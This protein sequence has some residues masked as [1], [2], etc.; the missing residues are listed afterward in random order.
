MTSF[1][2]VNALFDLTW[3]RHYKW[4][5]E[6]ERDYKFKFFIV[7][8]QN[9]HIENTIVYCYRKMSILLDY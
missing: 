3:N 2:T 9:I 1:C 7:V 4:T 8:W 6:K 5:N